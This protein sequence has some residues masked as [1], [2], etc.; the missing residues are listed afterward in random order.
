MTP[1]SSILSYIFGF[2][3]ALLFNALEYSEL[4]V[5]NVEAIILP[6]VSSAA[7]AI[8]LFFIS[9]A[10]V[11]FENPLGKDQAYPGEGNL[12]EVKPE[13]EVDFT[14]KIE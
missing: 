4:L 5:S 3:F 7:D 8:Y 14:D 2:D 13:D 1:N 9:C 6:I 10:I 11:Q 12:E